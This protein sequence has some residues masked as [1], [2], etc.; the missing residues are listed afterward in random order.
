MERH[1]YR[2]RQFVLDLSNLITLIPLQT[3]TP[4]CALW[5][6]I[7]PICLS[8]LGP[9]LTGSRGT[10]GTL[11]TI[12]FFALALSNCE[13]KCRGWKG[14][15]FL[16][17]DD[18]SKL[19]MTVFSLHFRALRRGTCFIHPEDLFKC[20]RCFRSPVKIVYDPNDV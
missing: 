8:P 14:Y 9:R 1:G 20:S 16:S 18:M 6:W 19:F 12:T 5:R 2:Y 17:K 4:S 7:S 11:S 3:T 15:V 10:S 13:H